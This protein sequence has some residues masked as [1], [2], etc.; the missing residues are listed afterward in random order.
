MDSTEI[1]DIDI[2]NVKGASGRN[3]KVFPS[4]NCKIF[5]WRNFTINLSTGPFY[6]NAVFH[7]INQYIN[8]KSLRCVTSFQGLST[9]GKNDSIFTDGNSGGSGAGRKFILIFEQLKSLT[10]RTYTCPR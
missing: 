2:P 7:L 5:R 1:G 4:Q 3:G 9:S 6:N 10:T 8:I